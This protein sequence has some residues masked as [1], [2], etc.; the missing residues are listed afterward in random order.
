MLIHE[1]GEKRGFVILN[2]FKVLF[3]GEKIIEILLIFLNKLVDFKLFIKLLSK[4]ASFFVYKNLFS[5]P[6]TT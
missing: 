6:H 3:W 2:K 1:T 5:S 4:K